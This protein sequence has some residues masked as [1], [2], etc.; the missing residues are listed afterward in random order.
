MSKSSDVEIIGVAGRDNEE[1][2][3]AFIDGYALGDLTHLS[4]ESGE[5]WSRFGVTSQPSWLFINDDGTHDLVFGRL[6]TDGLRARIDTLMA[7]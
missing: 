5:I 6:G 2:M 3:Q 1:A 4:D 7:S